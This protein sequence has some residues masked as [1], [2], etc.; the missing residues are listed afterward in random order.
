DPGD[1][2]AEGGWVSL[3][4]AWAWPANRRMLYNRASAD[5]EGNPWAERKRHVWW[6]GEKWTGYDV[7]DFPADKPPGYRAPHDA[8]GMDAISGD[9]PFIMMADG[10]AWL[11]A[12]AGPLGV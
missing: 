3:N 10:R 4:W 9:D 12:P 6:D 5:P 11:D 2:D 7:P 8:H 1:L